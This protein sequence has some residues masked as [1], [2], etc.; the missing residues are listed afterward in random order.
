MVEPLRA[1]GEPGAGLARD[2]REDR[3]LAEGQDAEQQ[4]EEQQLRRR[5]AASFMNCG[6]N[7]AKKT[8]VLGL[9][10]PTMNPARTARQGLAAPV[11]VTYR[12]R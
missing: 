10:A 1:A 5:G 8:M 12:W 7:A 6:R 3:V 2:Q 4:S 9:V 11:V